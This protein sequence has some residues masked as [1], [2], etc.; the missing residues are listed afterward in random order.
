M[1]R[2][3]VDTSAI[4]ALV[5]PSDSAHERARTAFHRLAAEE[6]VLVT[7]SYVLLET[8]ALVTRRLGIKAVRGFRDKLVP[9]LEILWVAADLHERGVQLLLD[10]AFRHFSLVDAVSFEA[11]GEQSI[12]AVFAFDRHFESADYPLIA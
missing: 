11:I 9:L 6:A 3:F 4:L 2:V 8:Y 10:R 1:R 5:V 12:D 7:T